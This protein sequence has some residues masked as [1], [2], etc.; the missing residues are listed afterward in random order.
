MY[1]YIMSST[2][3]YYLYYIIIVVTLVLSKMYN[4]CVEVGRGQKRYTYTAADVLRNTHTHTHT[5]AVA[6]QYHLSI[7]AVTCVQCLPTR[8]A[9]IT[10][11]FLVYLRLAVYAR[12]LSNLISL[13]R[14]YTRT[15]SKYMSVNKLLFVCS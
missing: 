1:H 4:T 5:S 7:K 9:V 11:P 2:P 8:R 6:T 10:Q 14:D 3:H 15:A 13:T 12:N